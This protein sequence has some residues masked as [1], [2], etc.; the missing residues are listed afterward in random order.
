MAVSITQPLSRGWQRMIAS[1]FKPFDIGKWFAIGFTAF[2]AG[3]TDGPFHWG[4]NNARKSRHWD[5]YDLS[6]IP[7][8]IGDWISY[9]PFWAMMI[10]IGLFL[11]LVLAIAL[12]WLS[13][14]G[15]FM[16]LDNVVQNTLHASQSHLDQT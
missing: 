8:Y 1:L 9:H 11:L 4:A 14:R 3:L 15:A 13:S 2:L 12:T 7:G 5:W 10:G 16:F 6:D